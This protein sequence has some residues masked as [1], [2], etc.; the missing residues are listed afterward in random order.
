MFCR[1]QR[2]CTQPAL[3]M[4]A[5]QLVTRT[6]FTGRKNQ[7][8]TH[9]HTA[10]AL[11]VKLPGYDTFLCVA[12]VCTGTK[13]RLGLLGSERF[14]LPSSSNGPLYIVLHCTTLYEYLYEYSTRV[15]ENKVRTENSS[16]INSHRRFPA[17]S[18]ATPRR[19]RGSPV[20]GQPNFRSRAVSPRMELHS[21]LR[22]AQSAATRVNLPREFLE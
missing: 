1:D 3:F 14:E 22:V 10:I 6:P 15:S 8:R 4:C 9:T 2:T 20:R 11:R 5:C 21:A 13:N 12:F 16:E 17:P 7:Q 18:R 19:A